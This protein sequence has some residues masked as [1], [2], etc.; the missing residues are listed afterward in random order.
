MRA[1][2]LVLALSAVPLLACSGDFFKACT[3]T[4]VGTTV[5]TTKEVTTGVAEGIAEGRKSGASIDGALLVST[6]DEV[7]ANGGLAVVSVEA[8]EGGG[9]RVTLAVENKGEQPMRVMNLELSALDTDGFVQRPRSSVSGELTVPPRAKERIIIE[10]DIPAEKVG[11]LRAW[12]TDL[13]L[14]T[15]Q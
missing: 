4:V 1:L 6:M 3:A 9:S 7:N 12:T 14:P 2:K 15:A 13:P 8:V 5:E 11:V 10:L